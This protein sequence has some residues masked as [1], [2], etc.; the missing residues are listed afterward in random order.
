MIIEEEIID[1]VTYKKVIYEESDMATEAQK[2][3]W[4][5]VCNTCEYKQDDRCGYCGCWLENIMSFATSTCPLDK[6]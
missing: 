2:D 6:W 1:G 4:M 5:Q 3:A